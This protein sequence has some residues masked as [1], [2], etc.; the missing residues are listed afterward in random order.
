MIDIN[1]GICYII[2]ACKDNCDKIDFKPSKND[3]VIAADGGYDILNKLSLEADV[4]LGDF[5]SIEDM[6]FHKNV[7]KYSSEKDDTDTFLAYKHAYERGYRTFVILGGIG[8]RIDHTLANII[9]LSDIAENG[10]IGYLIGNDTIITSITDSK[11]EFPESLRGN[12]SIFAHGKT[13]ENLSIKG[14]KYSVDN[15]SLS[16]SVTL[17][18]SNEFIGDRAEVSVENGTLLI[19]WSQSS[20]DFLKE[21]ENVTSN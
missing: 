4:L 16:P 14:L 20:N 18:V 17:G 3:I 19:I 8:G 7:V 5:D 11:I 12:I 1:K 21:I 2:A 9:T 13:A 6:P 15:I 10:G